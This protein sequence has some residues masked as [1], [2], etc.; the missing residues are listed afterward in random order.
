[1]SSCTRGNGPHP[2]EHSNKLRWWMSSAACVRRL[3]VVAV[4]DAMGGGGGV[5]TEKFGCIEVVYSGNSEADSY[6]M[7]LVRVFL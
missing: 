2:S 6:I 4:W 7:I 3:Q 1:M 5:S